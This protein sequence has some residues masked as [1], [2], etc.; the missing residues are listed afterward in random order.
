MGM[1][2]CIAACH[3]D[4]MVSETT[5]ACKFFHTRSQLVTGNFRTIRIALGVLSLFASLNSTSYTRRLNFFL[6][7]S[8]AYGDT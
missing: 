3:V 1:I 6:V 7:L 5:L 2:P 4:F 8:V